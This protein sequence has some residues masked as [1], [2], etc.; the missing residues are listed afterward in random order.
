MIR[1]LGGPAGIGASCLHANDD[2]AW[3]GPPPA[4]GGPVAIDI[5]PAFAAGLTYFGATYRSMYVNNN[6]NISF[7][8]ALSTYTPSPFPITDQPM[9]APW[10]ADVD[11][12]GG[13]QPTRNDVCFAVQSG[14][15]VVTWDRVGYFASHDDRQDT[16]Q[17]VL[18][19]SPGFAAGDFDVEFRYERCDWTT[20]DASGGTGGMGG[21][22]AQAA[23]D[24]GD[25]MNYMV[26]PMSRT[27]DVVNLCTTSNV[28]LSGIRSYQARGS[29][30]SPGT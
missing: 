15:I 20:G 21:T 5:S 30:I 6:G 22:A 19:T 17:L 26:L 8:G 24:A 4:T 1:S 10:W 11:T 27:A 16:F 9:I 2:G 7:R 28:G 14:L 3:A 18:R 13:G 25:R 12:R 29:R 23:F